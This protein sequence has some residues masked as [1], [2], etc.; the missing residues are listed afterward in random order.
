M[1]RAPF[2]LCSV[3][4]FQS[5]QQFVNVHFNPVALQP[6]AESLFHRHA[7]MTHRVFPCRVPPV[8]LPEM[9][10]VKK[11][12]LVMRFLQSVQ[13]PANRAGSVLRRWNHNP[14]FTNLKQASTP[15][16]RTVRQSFLAVN[17]SFRI[18]SKPSVFPGRQS[19]FPNRQQTA[20]LSRLP[21]RL[22]RMVSK[23]SVFPDC[24]FVFPNRQL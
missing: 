19:V 15:L 6:F 14:A 11:A 5:P 18:V 22:F 20:G 16:Y 9:V 2:T 21:I 10:L 7:A 17:P 8:F 23:L 13:F 4:G 24:P 3:P 1:V 12:V